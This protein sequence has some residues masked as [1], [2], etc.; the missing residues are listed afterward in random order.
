MVDYIDK[1]YQLATKK[2]GFTMAPLD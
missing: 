1:H 2:N